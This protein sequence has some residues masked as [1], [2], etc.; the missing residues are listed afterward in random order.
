M[1]DPLKLDG[2]LSEKNVSFM[3]GTPSKKELFK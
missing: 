3:K 2:I 1:L